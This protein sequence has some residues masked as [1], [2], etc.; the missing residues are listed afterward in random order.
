MGAAASLATAGLPEKL[1]RADV[2]QL[3][4]HKYTDEQFESMCDKDGFITS[5]QF[6]QQVSQSPSC[7]LCPDMYV[8]P[9]P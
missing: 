6:V 4:D 1:S 2:K 9:S 8:T 5:Q 3:S 7:H